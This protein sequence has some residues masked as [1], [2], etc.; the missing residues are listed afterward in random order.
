MGRQAGRGLAPLHH[1]VRTFRERDRAPARTGR[2]KTMWN[3]AQ[4]H[5]ASIKIEDLADAIC[6]TNEVIHSFN[7]D[8]AMWRGHADAGW[9]LQACVFRKPKTSAEMASYNET[10]L[11]GHFLMRAPTRSH[12]KT[13]E[14]SDYFGWLSLAQHYGLPTRLLDWSENPLVAA[15]FAVAEPSDDDGCIGALSPTDLNQ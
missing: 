9:A 12:A 8:T 14:P 1:R 7:Q 2:R 10:A 5:T 11:M 13:P 6:A 15:Y 4:H 3:D